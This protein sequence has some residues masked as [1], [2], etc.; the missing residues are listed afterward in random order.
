[1]PI[2]AYPLGLEHFQDIWIWLYIPFAIIYGVFIWFQ[3]H[4]DMMKW[5]FIT[6]ALFL[7]V[8]LTVIP[9][10]VGLSAGILEGV[11]F[12]VIVAIVAVPAAFVMGFVYVGLAIVL[13]AL[14]RKKKWLPASS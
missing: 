14:F 10:W 11:Q 9:S 7:T 13:Y 2:L 5:V 3:P 1:M 8:I 12:F 4:E 6:P